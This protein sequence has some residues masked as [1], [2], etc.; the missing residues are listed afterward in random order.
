MAYLGPEVV[1][2]SDELNNWPD[3]SLPR[4]ILPQITSPAEWEQGLRTLTG[5]TAPYA[6]YVPNIVYI[7]LGGEE[8][9]SLTVNRGYVPNKTIHAEPMAR[10]PA[11]DI[12]LAARGV[13]GIA[14]ELFF[15]ISYE[16]ASAFLLQF[17]AIKTLDD[18]R[19]FAG[20]YKIPR[21]SAKFW[22]FVDWLH[23][24]MAKHMPVQAGILELKLYDKGDL[25]F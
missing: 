13:S 4:K 12:L 19:S 24:W 6:Q 25:P 9:Y 15:D 10:R 21:T 2:P 16:E 5:K 11:L 7:R 18:W 22:P 1:G 14:P 17:S 3:S 8:L 20:A 23:D